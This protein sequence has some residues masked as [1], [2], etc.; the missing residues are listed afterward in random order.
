MAMSRAVRRTVRVVGVALV[1]ALAGLLAL[2]IYG[3][4]RLAAAEREFTANVGPMAGSPD[5]LGEG[6]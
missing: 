5:A 3:D 2:R 6:S 4:R 1:V